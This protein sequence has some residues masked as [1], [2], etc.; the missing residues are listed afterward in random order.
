VP[1]GT[2]PPSLVFLDSDQNCETLSNPNP[3]EKKRSTNEVFEREIEKKL[4]NE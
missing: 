2:P 4:K 3:S 1:S